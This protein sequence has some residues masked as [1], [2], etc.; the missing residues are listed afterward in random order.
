MIISSSEKL[1]KRKRQSQRRNPMCLPG[2]AFACIE[3]VAQII[4]DSLF[5]FL[6]GTKHNLIRSD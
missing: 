1:E 6:A 3:N 5:P 2:K 4:L